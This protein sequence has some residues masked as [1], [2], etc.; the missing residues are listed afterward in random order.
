MLVK[1]IKIYL[2]YICGNRVIA[3]TYSEKI[4]MIRTAMNNV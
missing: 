4:G 2:M 3:A 1:Q